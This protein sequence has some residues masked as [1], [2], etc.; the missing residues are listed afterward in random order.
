MLVNEGDVEVA[1]S[2]NQATQEIFNGPSGTKQLESGVEVDVLIAEAMK[3]QGVALDEED[4][5]A[6]VV[7]D[8]ID[9]PRE[10]PR[11]PL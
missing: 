3:K 7:A 5:V 8:Y 6:A 1:S 10:Y 9:T 4:L 11:V 2:G